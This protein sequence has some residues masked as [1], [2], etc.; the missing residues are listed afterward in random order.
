MVVRLIAERAHPNSVSP[1][2]T[3]PSRV[4]SALL[5][6]LVDLPFLM[7]AHVCLALKP[8]CALFAVE[9]PECRQVL[10]VLGVFELREVSFVAQVGVDLV[11]VTRVAARLLLG[12]LTPNSW[13]RERIWCVWFPRI[14][15]SAAD[16]VGYGL[17]KWGYS[18]SAAVERVS[19]GQKNSTGLQ[20]WSV[21]DLAIS[22]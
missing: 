16:A 5:P 14:V 6:P 22:E 11:D 7:C 3:F 12:L 4:R 10:G 13:H 15:L 2:L 9:L 17:E 1:L 19:A 21:P 8:F 18:A 20:V